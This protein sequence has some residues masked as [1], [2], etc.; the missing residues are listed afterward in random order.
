M[1]SAD[2]NTVTSFNSQ[3]G[4][5]AGIVTGL[6]D[7]CKTFTGIRVDVPGLFKATT[8]GHTEI[9]HEQFSAGSVTADSQL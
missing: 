1:I 6:A 9:R 3:N 2:L 7:M 8:L 5:L 4:D